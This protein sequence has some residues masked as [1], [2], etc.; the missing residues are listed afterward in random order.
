M[1]TACIT[2]LGFDSSDFE[3]MDCTFKLG[4][5]LSFSS[6]RMEHLVDVCCDDVT[7]VADVLNIFC[8]QG[9]CRLESLERAIE[10]E[11]LSSA[12]FDAVRFSA[13]I[14]VDTRLWTPFQIAF[15]ISS[16]T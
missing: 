13:C 15:C 16:K 4:I 11:D 8:V 9:R 1:D 10:F 2:S 12:V 14:L 6:F 5:Y 7:L 3:E